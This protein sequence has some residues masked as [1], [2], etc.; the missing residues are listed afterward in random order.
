MNTV[1][2]EFSRSLRKQS[3]NI[4][5]QKSKL[6]FGFGFESHCAALARLEPYVD[7]AGFELGGEFLSSSG[8]ILIIS[9]IGFGGFTRQGYSV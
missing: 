4:Q 6:G 2:R 1:T 5:K 9:F 3:V 8:L 7:K